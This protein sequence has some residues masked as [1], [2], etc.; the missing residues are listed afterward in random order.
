MRFPPD[1]IICPQYLG[2]KGQMDD[3]DELVFKSEFYRLTAL[4]KREFNKR[5][6]IDNHRLR[7]LTDEAYRTYPEN[8]GIYE[9]MVKN[10]EMRDELNKEKGIEKPSPAYFLTIRPPPSIT[11]A[12]FQKTVKN[13]FKKSSIKQYVYVYE[14]V[15]ETLDEI[16]KGFHIHA[17][18]WRGDLKPSKLES[19]IDNTFKHIIDLD[20]VQKYRDKQAICPFYNL[21][22]VYENDYQNRLQY[23]LG[24]KDS[25]AKQI[26]Q[27]YDKPFRQKYGLQDFYIQGINLPDYYTPRPLD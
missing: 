16:G 9:L 2:E 24:K 8:K 27:Q 13:Q 25:P 26:K 5:V 10:N 21:Y 14:Q 19:G 17:L 6:V 3:F 11:F 1:Q 20:Q 7:L 18:I 23:I 15:G 22:R 4:A 12:E